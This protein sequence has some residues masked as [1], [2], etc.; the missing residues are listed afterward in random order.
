MLTELRLV[1]FALLLVP[2]TTAVA[3]D[4]EPRIVTE[5]LSD[6]LYVL[7]GGNGQGSNV[8]VS[9]GEDGI[10]LIDAMRDVSSEK[11]L[12]AIRAISDKPIKYVINTHSD[13]DHSGGN[14][15]FADLGATII[16]QNNARYSS[17]MSHLKV[18]DNF[19]LTFNNNDIE[20]QHVVAH[21]YNDL[22]VYLPDDNVVFMGDTY[23]N[24]SYPY[25]YRL[26]MAGQFKALDIAHSFADKGTIFVPGHG[27]FDNE[28]GLHAFR[29]KCVHWLARVGALFRQG[30]GV[31]AMGEDLELDQI[32]QRFIEKRDPPIL[33]D[34][35]Y[36]GFIERTL[37]A[38]FVNAY[39]MS[40]DD[41]NAYV[42]IYQLE[43]GAI[44]EVLQMDASL[45]ARVEG[46]HID[47]LIAL[48]PTLFHV[49]VS[50]GDAY[51]FRLSKKGVADRV[52]I[53]T[54]DESQ[55]GKRI[56]PAD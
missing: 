27:L 45:I 32:K 47:T 40:Q 25:A 2:L 1:V 13:F 44:L 52:T 43:D 3:Q 56:N 19:V 4:E 15:F 6:N 34:T 26:G 54:G 31:D 38:D 22:I 51:N 36:R 20:A 5:K 46:S 53:H 50:L 41:L 11:L 24:T 9:I 17:A 8:G 42:G 21:S 49:R 14:Q 10:L 48:S 18:A 7:Y 37:S 16:A 23:T 55:N 30:V 33:S 35:L 29:E 28:K 39:P 12:S